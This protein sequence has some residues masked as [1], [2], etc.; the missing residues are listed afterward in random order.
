M[1]T[2]DLDEKSGTKIGIKTMTKNPSGDTTNTQGRMTSRPSVPPANIRPSTTMGL[3]QENLANEELRPKTAQNGNAVPHLPKLNT[4]RSLDSAMVNQKKSESQ[5]R[6]QKPMV[7]NFM[8]S[9]RPPT[10]EVEESA[11]SGQQSMSRTPS[12]STLQSSASVPKRGPRGRRMSK[13]VSKALMRAQQVN[14][15][16]A[17]E[18]T[19]DLSNNPPTS[20]WDAFETHLKSVNE[21][22]MLMEFENKTLDFKCSEPFKKIMNEMAPKPKVKK[23]ERQESESKVGVAFE[24]KEEDKEEDSD[25]ESDLDDDLEDDEAQTRRRR[26]RALRAWALIKRNIQEM[27]MER[28]KSAGSINWDFLRQTITALT[29]ME[30][31][32]QELYDKYIYKPNW[33]ADGLSQCP[34]HLLRKYSKGTAGMSAVKVANLANSRRA[35]TAQ[36]RPGTSMTNYSTTSRRA[37]TPAGG[38]RR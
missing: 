36:K 2:T 23:P 29:D 30:K 18:S 33:W 22:N 12:Q 14:D 4:Q 11:R 5:D 20:A 17:R 38:P 10:R 35:N 6:K 7:N 1:R 8:G 9:S 31:A 13:R 34:D 15:N 32:R 27:R 3:Y 37:G 19:D 25:E 24:E 21:N 28:R 26:R 16:S